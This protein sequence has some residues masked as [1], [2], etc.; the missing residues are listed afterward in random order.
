MK[1]NLPEIRGIARLERR[2]LTD[3]EKTAGF[4][5]AIRG[6]IPF[7]ADSQV[8]KRRDKS[9]KIRP[10][11]ERIAPEAF[12]RS[13]TEDRDIVA[14]AGHAE[15]P[16]SAFAIL[17]ENLTIET[18]DRSMDWEAKVP[19]TQAGRDLM[20]LVDMGIIKG[21]SFEFLPRENGET[22]EKRGADMDVRTI[23]DARLFEVNPV[24]W[25]AYLGTSLTVEMRG[26]YSDDRNEAHDS[27]YYGSD[28]TMTGPVRYV[29]GMLGGLIAWLT[30]SLEYLRDQ[31]DSTLAAFARKHVDQVAEQITELTAWLKENGATPKPDD[32]SERATRAL[33][34]FRKECR[35]SAPIEEKSVSHWER[36][37]A[38]MSKSPAV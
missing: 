4:I 34:E 30:N 19:D 35:Q 31:P 28:G 26:R 36:Q 20:T 15:D 18:N 17:G 25:P 6:S 33:E 9:G 1:P 21:T 22:W 37:L 24:K 3:E 38:F 8:M 14:T 32:E 5:G 13:L 10:F 2:S 7:N 16:L 12:T 29:E 23:T 11:V 27:Y